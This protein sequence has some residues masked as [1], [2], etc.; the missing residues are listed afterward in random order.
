[1]TAP[2]VLL[3]RLA[4]R[5]RLE[6]AIGRLVTGGTAG[7]G[8]GGLVH[9]AGG[10]LRGV[11]LALASGLSGGL[12][13][14]WAAERSRP[15]DGQA[16]ARHLDRALPELEES[17]SLLLEPAGHGSV[18]TALQR[19]RVERRWDPAR[20]RAA[21]PRTE[22]R[23][24]SMAGLSL[25]LAGAALLLLPPSPR[26]IR[27]VWAPGSE[28]TRLTLRAL[29]V[30]VVPPVYTGLPPHHPTGADFEAE[31]GSRVTW[32]LATAGP[33]EAAW[34]I[35]SA[36]DSLPFQADEAG[37]WRAVCSAERSLLF[38]VRLRHGDSL[39]LTS[40]DYRLAVRPDRPPTLTIVRP[41]ERTSYDPDTLPP[42]A[43]EVLA[44]DDYG[45]DS[46]ALAATIATG[47]GEAVRFRRLRLPLAERKRRDGHGELLRSTLDLR[48]LGLGPGDELYFHVEATDR[49]TPSPNRSR[50]ETV[51][52]SIRD[53]TRTATAYL[54]RLAI[55]AQ[56]E[57]FRSQRQ[58]IIDTEK[59]L[60]DEG[61]LARA[62]F[63]DRSNGLGMDQGLL[64]LRYGQFLGEEFEEELQPK[65][66]RED[67]GSTPDQQPAP[68]AGDETPG[69]RDDSRARQNK[70]ADKL[71][72]KHD[73]AEN[74]TLLGMSVKD[75]LRA[76]VG[77]MWQAELDLRTA[78]PG[79]ALPYMYHAL[80]LIKQVQQDARVY[81]QRVGFEPPPIEVDRLRLTGKLKD[82]RDQE[83]QADDRRRDSLPSVRAALALLQADPPALNAEGSLNTI[84]AAGQELAAL[85]VDDPR[86]LPVLRDLR[87]LAD[88]VA[89][90]APCGGCE[91]RAIRGLWSALP[92]A[93]PRLRPAPAGDSPLARRFATLLRGAEQ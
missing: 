11:A 41:E 24:A 26:G 53:T 68:E 64:R 89:R 74:A 42:V 7:L 72:H 52:I 40:D 93:E 83:L 57:Y 32:R 84:T 78:E 15:I 59:L 67:A 31:E 63:R 60:A 77:A 47:R 20:A 5:Y 9:Y 86:L 27:T 21:L 66:G 33:V 70:A 73:E 10:G 56:P 81:V 39:T 51:F 8:L 58:L 6:R 69:N 48:A 45:V 50:S 23:R 49:K 61:K 87:Q 30:E 36:G 4:G 1:M 13:A 2:A 14:V 25:A 43:V 34:L 44:N 28:S 37:S 80:E 3:T 82:I 85:A 46:V 29:E 91:A 88:S 55:G 92:P 38:R 76:A 22:V 79:R 90:R 18:L 75:K 12:L 71:T 35:P 62:A 54:A 19:A 16:V 17:A 65:G